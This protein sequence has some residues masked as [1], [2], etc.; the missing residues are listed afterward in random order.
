MTE[1]KSAID[2][3]AEGAGEPDQ[4]LASVLRG[5]TSSQALRSQLAQERSEESED[6]L[7][8]LDALDFV[9]QVVGGT[10][11]VPQRIA[12]Y[13]I[14]G[15]LGRGGMGTVY[16]GYQEELDREVALKVLSPHLTADPTMRKRFRAEARATAALHHR[17]IVPIYD[18]GEAQ[19]MLFF[20]MERVDG[21]SLD[22]HIAAARR[23]Q[24]K[25]M[26]PLE[27]ARRFAG[28]ADALGLAHRRRLLH[29]DV[30]PGNILVV[31]D[32]TLALTDF[33][34]AKALDHASARL[35]SK[36][37]GFLGTLHYSSPEQ[38]LGSELTPA[39]DLY[40]LGVTIFEAVAGEL[41]FA[42]KTTESLLQ[43]ILHGTPRRLREFEPKA[44]RDLD[45]V[46]E[47]L[48][49]REPSDRYQD[50]EA[51]SRDLLRIRDGEPV[52]IRRLPLYVRVYRRARKNPG[53]ASAIAAAGIL[54]LLTVFLL[55]VWRREKGQGLLSK[56][57]NH[58]VQI[59]TDVGNELG[60][61]PGPVPLLQALTGIE[62]EPR[63]PSQTVLKSLEAAHKEIPDDA[64]VMAMQAAYVEDPLPQAS[65]LL[66]QGRG[67]EALLLYDQAIGAATLLR[68]GA[69][70]DLAV[71]LRLYR[72]YLGRSV[73]NLCAAVAKVHDARADLALAS[74]LRPGATFPRSLLSV[75]DVVQSSDVAAAAAQLERDIE[76]A[77]A[78]RVQVLGHL[79]WS[80]AAL[81]PLPGANLMNFALGYPQRRA[82][83]DLAARLLGSPPGASVAAGQPTG[84][85]ARL[86]DLARLAMERLA[87]PT[88]LRA[89]TEQARLEVE[90]CVHPESPLRGWSGVLQ[91]IEQP[92]QR[93]PLVDAAGRPLSPVLQLAAWHDL[94]LLSPKRETAGFWLGRFENL[95][96]SHANL[97]GMRRVAA[98]M[99]LLAGSP[100]APGLIAEW[101]AEAEGEPMAQL[102]RMRLRLRTGDFD[103]ALTDA[104]VTVQD[105]VDREAALRAVLLC[106]EEIADEADVVARPRIL[107][108]Q[109]R[110]R[111]LLPEEAK[112]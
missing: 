17:H 99:Y 103:G 45:A 7:S 26:E 112:R 59:R 81:R 92:T 43:A 58:L 4:R 75:L 96:R 14:K 63:S 22:K 60:A 82:L 1:P 105:S 65:Q 15:L 40:A 78:E 6:L 110:F 84:L 108:L 76:R 51:L 48:L 104:M 25:P 109:Q 73:A 23:M 95:F 85:S 77:S 12:D 49:S 10:T 61:Q 72:L 34:L 91:L 2:G 80:A 93:G 68:T 52:H 21:M 70:R 32:G 36:G 79:L 56:H 33:G 39:S 83:H 101:I 66:R 100:Q 35:T 106:C 16:L 9:Q 11:D 67:H 3:A 86:A 27:A 88:A 98:R 54:L 24:R 44:P 41:P 102:C 18:Y 64:Q 55:T 90:S 69:E 57:Q 94:L 19:G 13:H 53:L 87:D 42:A 89:A 50:G 38:A 47:K 28:V 31:G 97:P 29:R 8:R 74:Y 111:G 71:D 46:V 62:Y 107:E 30:K 5:E 20:T 37:G